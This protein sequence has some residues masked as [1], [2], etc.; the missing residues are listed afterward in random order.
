MIALT[1]AIGKLYHLLLADRF[2]NFIKSNQLL[3]TELQKAFLKGLNGTLDHTFIVSEIMRHARLNHRSA[4]LT[5]FD[6][7]DAFGSVPHTLI[8]QT[9]VRN[10]FPDAIIQ[11]VSQLY[12]ALKGQVI[13]PNWTSNMFEF[14]RGVFQGDPLSPL[15][16][17]LSFNPIIDYIKSEE[18]HGYYLKKASNIRHI[19]NPFADDF[20]L[21]TCRTDTHQRIINN[22]HATVNTMG[23]TLKP[24]KCRSLSIV[25]GSFTP[26]YFKIGETK[27]D[28]VME[29]THKYLGAH[30]TK[31]VKPA[32]IF[33]LT[34]ELINIR[35]SNID[36]APIRDEYKF[37]IYTKY[38]LPSLRYHLTVHEINGTD[39]CKLDTLT[40]TFLRK[41]LHIPKSGRFASG[42]L[43][44]RRISH[45]YKECHASAFV[46]LKHSNDIK[47]QDALNS[48]LEREAKLTRKFSIVQYSRDLYEKAVRS[49]T[50]TL[51]FSGLK[52]KSILK[53]VKDLVSDEI[54]QLW[55][56]KVKTLLVQGKF[57]DILKIEKSCFTW[58]HII[59][60][61]P[62]GVLQFI[63]N[64][65]TDSLPTLAN[66]GRWRQRAVANTKCPLCGNCQTLHHILNHCQNM[67]K[68]G[69]YTWRHDSILSYLFSLFNNDPNKDTLKVFVDLGDH[70]WQ[71]NSTIPQDILPTAQRPDLVLYWPKLKRIRIFELSVPFETN[72]E[73]T[74][75]RKINKYASLVSDL[76]DRDMDVE[77]LA[78]E[79]GSRGYI[80]PDNCKRL[81]KLIKLSNTKQSFKAV[82]DNLTKIA[83][84]TSFSIFCSKFEPSWR[85][86]PIFKM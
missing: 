83:L 75:T 73:A 40:H 23:L 80:S 45:I 26:I 59:Y 76:Q 20:N 25:G 41:W 8:T 51:P 48:K 30:I 7:K 43:E 24:S 72:I 63:L 13:T 57:L 55:D 36:H 35:L 22:I 58:K 10:K 14:K 82:R 27:I 6:L 12:D 56:D 61:L 60:Q 50:H 15:I 69:R 62:R 78:F 3:D 74:H 49:L 67:L 1:S 53:N 85:D 34:H 46:H 11:Y 64:A 81:K 37:A 31:L 86:P 79:V 84:S 70:D 2:D 19:V 44:L 17:L 77:L 42:S 5:W 29:K 4:H 65:S 66:L 39:L 18:K 71:V 38:F 28:T 32:V 52:K 16:F 54:R 68:Q 9:L 21:A 33:N 47:V